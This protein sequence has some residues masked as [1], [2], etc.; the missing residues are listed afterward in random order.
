MSQEITCELNGVKYLLVDVFIKDKNDKDDI[1]KKCKKYGAVYQG[2]KELKQG[3]FFSSGY[4]ILKVLVPE[5][6]VI[7]WNDEKTL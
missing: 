6:N 5:K 2:V 3:G 4:A 7:A 1:T